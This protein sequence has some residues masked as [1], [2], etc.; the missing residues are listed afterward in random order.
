MIIRL[1]QKQEVSLFSKLFRFKITS[2]NELEW[3]FDIFVHNFV[4]RHF[5]LMSNVLIGFV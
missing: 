1:T 2:R 4:N 5:L 3:K